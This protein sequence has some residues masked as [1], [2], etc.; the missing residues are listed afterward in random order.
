M[1][2][3]NM[4]AAVTNYAGYDENGPY[5]AQDLET[6]YDGTTWSKLT[7]QGVGA[8]PGVFLLRVLAMVSGDN[9]AV[10]LIP[11]QPATGKSECSRIDQTW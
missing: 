11:G 10:E 4:T 3:W 1:I 9:K 7:L 2:H 5:S 6:Y 8:N